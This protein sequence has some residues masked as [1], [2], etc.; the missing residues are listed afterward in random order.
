MPCLRDIVGVGDGATGDDH[1]CFFRGVSSWCFVAF[2]ELNSD[3]QDGLPS[4]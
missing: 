3:E 1:G 4:A 2:L